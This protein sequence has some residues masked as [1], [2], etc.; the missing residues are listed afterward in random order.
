MKLSHIALAFIIAALT[1]AIICTPG[2][3]RQQEIPS[4]A[5]SYPGGP[6]PPPPP[7]TLLQIL[8]RY[9]YFAG[10]LSIAGAIVVIT[11]GSI[12]VVVFYLR[13]R[14]QPPD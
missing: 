9:T 12:V 11:T 2:I 7:D 14:R 5:M 13:H 6:R 1:L 8:A 3:G 10:Y 4:P